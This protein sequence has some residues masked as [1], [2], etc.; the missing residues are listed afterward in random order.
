ML[1]MEVLKQVAQRHGFYCNMHEKPYAGINGSG[2]HNNFSMATD[3]GENL[4]EPGK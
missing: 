1:T 3:T 4:L 2:K